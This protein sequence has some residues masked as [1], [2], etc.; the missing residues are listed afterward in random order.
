MKK[1]ITI[2]Q[3]CSMIA[4][5]LFYCVAP[6]QAQNVTIGP[7]NGSI[8]TGQAGGN[9]GDSGIGRGMGSMWRHEQLPLT[10]T[11]SDIAMLTSA[12]ELADPSCAIDKYNGKLIIGAGQTQTFIVV[13]L[14]KGYR[15][16][17][18]RLEL[19]PNIYGTIRLHSGKNSWDISNDDV[20]RIYETEA[21]GS[22]A[23]YIIP[24][25]TTGN[26]S[27]THC[28][29]TDLDQYGYSYITVAHEIGNTNNLDMKND[30]EE[31][32]AKTFVINREAK[33]DQTTKEWDMGNQLHFFFA[34][35]ASQY[36]LT[37]KSFEITFTAEGTFNAGL[38]PVSVGE[39][40]SV[41]QS[42]FSTS[43]MDVGSIVWDEAKQLYLYDYTQVQELAAYNWMYQENAVA[44]GRPTVGDEDKHI[45]PVVVD[46]NGVYAFGNDTYFVEPP[47]TIETASGWNSPIGFR[48]VGAK[49]DYQWGSDT[50]GGTQT[51]VDVCYIRGRYPTDNGGT[52]S[53]D[54]YLNDHLDIINDRF[55][56]QIDEWGNIYKE[57]TN[58]AGDTYRKYLACFGSDEN[59]RVLSLSTSA[60]GAE[61][62]W[63]LRVEPA[64][65]NNTRHVYYEDSHGDRYYLNWRIRQEGSTYHSRCYLTKN[66]TTNLC[67]ATTGQTHSIN[68]P[69]FSAGSY[70]LEIY[71]TDKDTPVETVTVNSASDVG[72]YTVKNLNNDAVKFKISNLAE[73]KQAIVNVTLMLEA[74][75][76]YIDKM[77]IVCH[78]DINP[79]TGK[80]NLELTQSFTSN[81]FSVSGGKFIFYVPDDYSDV[82]LTFTFSDLYSKYGDNT[83]YNDVDYLQMNGNARYSYVTSDYFKLY[84]GNTKSGVTGFPVNEG[85]YDNSYTPNTDYKTKV[86]TSTAGNIRFKFNNAENLVGGTGT[87]VEYPFTVSDYI[88]STDPDNSTE[89]GTFIPCVL[90]ANPEASPT[91]TDYKRSDIFYV[92]TADETRYNIAPT[93][94]LQHRYYAFY[95]MD[96]ELEARTFTPNFTYTPIYDKTF[97]LHK[98]P[99]RDDQGNI[100]KVDGKIQYD[101]M[102][103]EE[104]MWGLKLDV[105]TNEGEEYEQGYL[106]YQEIIDNILGRKAE[107]YT[108][109]E[110]T[111]YNT[112]NNLSEGDSNY[113]HEGDL[114]KKA[115]EST[116]DA[117]N[118]NAPKY[119]RQ[120]LYVDGT[121]L[122]A[123]LNSSENAV[124]KT[125]KDL[126]DSLAVNNLVFLPENTTS[127]LDN[128]AYQ[129]G[130]GAFRAGKN[131][132]LTD[133]Q[134]FYTPYSIQVASAD[135]ASYSRTIPLPPED[136]DKNVTVMLPFTLTH[137]GGTHTNETGTPGAGMSFSI[138]T[139]E[140]ENEMSVEGINWG[141]AYFKPIQTTTTEANKPY[142]IKIEK[143]NIPTDATEL[144]FTVSQ[145]GSGI[146]KTPD[147]DEVP[148]LKKEDKM[149]ENEVDYGQVVAICT[150]KLFKGADTEGT[151]TITNDNGSDY[152]KTYSFTNYASYSG[153]K[154]DRA[155]TENVFYFGTT[156]NKYVDLHTLS[157]KYRYLY[158]YPFRGVYY[159]TY[160]EE[161]NAT[162]AK[163]MRG[164]NICYGENPTETSETTAIKNMPQWADLMLRTG[165]R[166]I[167][168]TATKDQTVDIYSMNGIKTRNIEMNAGES[169]VVTVPSGV[170]VVN[171]TK[172][173]VR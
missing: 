26:E 13:S 90:I 35:G 86:Y 140:G 105:A 37:I 73:G 92:F 68:I 97:Q 31:N 63:N 40:T 42:P 60:T 123:M 146:Y 139:M 45:Y 167:T 119:M 70:T 120:I 94:A 18:Y 98:E 33:Q 23:P 74:L 170:Y 154:F 117:S 112:K 65:G 81:D 7:D 127:T 59:E 138:N 39:A 28:T 76:P 9:T 78:D 48:I 41:V 101:E 171:G 85:L 54:G 143:A 155:V 14:P 44:G 1:R 83:Y 121:P 6:T 126:K 2:K 136:E 172:I 95:R 156:N 88:G 124:I 20:M 153:N 148:K 24:G 5:M 165:K 3:L 12:G 19:Q 166:T 109:A 141:N 96:I 67:S 151:Y 118:T 11:T 72:S 103:I 17:G 21:W 8:I 159:Y 69:S 108:A 84:S 110:A 32:R 66:G 30:T 145:K 62:K 116:L 149:V 57:Y 10:M 52:S 135:Y 104:S 87:L 79:T 107:Y 168:L 51:L 58:P 173:V 147:F 100:I 132:V 16:T 77:D 61:A 128:V 131:I 22:V 99:K 91:G 144:E 25:A 93:T 142:M 113:K 114:K 129:M 47:T 56:W 49:F 134:P 164:F 89:T 125:L 43:K 150:G 162:G 160:T 163:F 55:A 115:I 53:R 169:R 161:G 82:P 4:F 64:N 27:N 34:R 122:Y 75:N 130:S 102:E 36:A 137:S 29:L 80:P 158:V 46:G 106:T 157:G 71:G 152:V 50:Q 133:K 15:I 111:A 38:T